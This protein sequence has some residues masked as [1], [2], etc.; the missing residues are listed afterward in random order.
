M[1]ATDLRPTYPDHQHPVVIATIP[2]HLV[3][4]GQGVAILVEDVQIAVFRTDDGCF[5][6]LSNR[7]PFTG[8]NVL[9]RGIVGSRKGIPIVSSPMRKHAFDLSTGQSL[10]D[11][12]VRIATFT[13]HDC[14]T[15]LDIG[16]SQ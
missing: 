9:A 13:V 10:D 4:A 7:D 3:G 6:A 8:A 12:A 1:T 5:Y 2:Q 15:T 14:G 16:V 11:P